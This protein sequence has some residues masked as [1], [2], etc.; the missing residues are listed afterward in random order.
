M[1]KTICDGRYF[2]NDVEV[3]ELDLENYDLA[4]FIDAQ[5]QTQPQLIEIP[6]FDN[7]HNIAIMET[8]HPDDNI[9]VSK[10]LDE[11]INITFPTIDELKKAA[12]DY[13]LINW[14][15]LPLGN[16]DTNHEGKAPISKNWVQINGLDLSL[17]NNRTVNIG[18]NCG[19]SKIICCDIDLAD[20]GLETWRKLCLVHGEPN[21]PKQATPKGGFHFI[22]K[23]TDKVSHLKSRSK[24]NGIGI[25]IKTTGGQFVVEPS[26]NRIIGKP[27]KW[28]ISPEKYLL[29]H[30]ELPEMPQWLID[31]YDYNQVKV[32]KPKVKK[33]PEAEKPTTE[34]E[35]DDLIN[36]V[37]I[38]ITKPIKKRTFEN[39]DREYIFKLIEHIVHTEIEQND[40]WGYQSWLDIGMAIYGLCD[41]EEE[42]AIEIWDYFS[43]LDIDNYKEGVDECELKIA[44]FAREGG[45]GLTKLEELAGPEKVADLKAKM[46]KKHI[47]KLNT[48]L[49]FDRNDDF[50][51]LDFDE[52]HR[53][54][55]YK[56]YEEMK[57]A[58]LEDLKKVFIIIEQGNGT[59]IKKDDCEDNI[60]TIIKGIKTNLFFS[61]KDDEGVHDVP[62][63]TILKTHANEIPRFRT[64][65]CHPTIKKPKAFNL[66]R[67]YKAQ[68]VDDTPEN[69]IKKI[70]PMLNFI[71]EVWCNENDDIFKYFMLWLYYLIAKPEEK[72]RVAIFAYS[73]KQQV[74]KNTLTD[75]LSKFVLGL[76]LSCD[77]IGLES[78][79]QKHNRILESNKLIIVNEASATKETFMSSFNKMKSLITE[80]TI[81]IEPKGIDAYKIENLSNFFILSNHKNSLLL[82]Q[83]TQRYLCLEINPK[84]RNNMP[85]W[86]EFRKICFNDEFGNYFYTYFNKVYTVPENIYI[87]T[88]PCTDLKNEIVAVSLPNSVRFLQHVKE[89]I[90]KY[91]ET[92]ISASELYVQYKI[93]CDANGERNVQNSKIFGLSIKSYIEK[94]ST[95]NC[96][97]YNLETIA[98]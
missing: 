73:E 44:T 62:F 47:D 48:G 33:E 70:E 28:I 96:N 24:T 74:G 14:V 31:F 64:M 39:F 80:P 58:V 68:L 49:H 55:K 2:I 7:K 8:R 61:Y 98:C 40:R 63:Q 75:F 59:I 42:D 65:Y 21:C 3:D 66:W 16:H 25:D 26:V 27:Y 43:R 22:F 60:Y 69:I 35:L 19:T 52:K 86:T 92:K 23:Y 67:G 37:E 79:L 95:K 91:D 57:N 18:I 6:K 20:K 29:E 38:G 53:G 41:Y 97:V 85:F 46:K 94:K 30:D 36:A 34:N 54:H 10:D 93:W 17:F 50:C 1:K 88:P 51:W 5:V 90:D 13:E 72:T 76:Q 11:K 56:S 89:N 9:L 78:L 71:K 87:Q 12:Q 82:E 84:Y 4:E 32:K 77:V 45:F 83:E 15:P 81:L